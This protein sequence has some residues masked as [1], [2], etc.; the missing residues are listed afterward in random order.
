MVPF[1]KVNAI[2]QL[3]ICLILCFRN[4]DP[5]E[6]SEPEGYPPLWDIVSER[7]EDF[8]IQNTKIIIN[9][10]NYLERMA[11][12]KILLNVTAQYLDMKEPDN[13]RNVLWGLPLQHGW[14]FHTGRLADPSKLTTC[15]QSNGDQTCI[16]EKSWWACMN[17]YLVVIPFLGGADAGFFKDVPHEIEISH[18]EEFDSDFCY[19]VTDCRSSCPKAMDKW[20]TFFEFIQAPKPLSDKSVPPLSKEEDV[21]LFHMWKAHVESIDAALPRCSKRLQYIPMPEGN[22]GRDWATAVEFIAATHFPTNF[23]STNNFQIFLPHRILVDGDEAPSI[24]DLT[25]EENRVLF[26]LQW[27]NKMN[28][29]TGGFVLR[30]WQKMM[31]SEEGR[32][33]G[34]NLLQNMVTDPN[35]VSRNILALL[36]ELAK[37]PPCEM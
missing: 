11:M 17:Y 21:L 30:L 24:G 10:W 6:L 16:S 22:F 25:E 31:C 14:Q 34:R 32:A 33:E 8:T 2:P 20:K 7:L 15:G 23:D 35:L 36:K 9:P 3:L 19:N 27:I 18:P 28:K 12:Y 26:I 13:K 29:V 5:R 1:S 4:A 37:N